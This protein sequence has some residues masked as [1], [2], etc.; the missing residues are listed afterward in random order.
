MPGWGVAF[1]DREM[2]ASTRKACAEEMF[3]PGAIAWLSSSANT[4]GSDR[5]LARITASGTRG[6]P[7]ERAN[8]KSVSVPLTWVASVGA[9]VTDP[10]TDFGAAPAGAR[11]SAFEGSGTDLPAA[12]ARPRTSAMIWATCEA[13]GVPPVPLKLQFVFVSNEA[14]PPQGPKS[15]AELPTG[16]LSID[17]GT[18]APVA[19]TTQPAGPPRVPVSR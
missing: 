10:D 5:A 7:S 13:S 15:V 14:A 3:M 2:R 17:M 6:P 19:V 9:S 18:P 16:P 1:P 8:T 4:I 12:A 11:A